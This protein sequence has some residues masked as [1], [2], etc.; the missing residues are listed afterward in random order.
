MLVGITSFG[1]VWRRRFRTSSD[2]SQRFRRAAYFNTTGVA[3][4]GEIVRHRKI[5]G[6]VRFNGVGGFN[7]YYPQRVLGSVFQCDEPAIWNRQNKVFC[8]RKLDHPER[9]DYFLVAV[10]SAEFGSVRVGT[11]S[12]KSDDTYLISFSEWRDTQEL[13]MLMSPNGWVRTQLGRVVMLHDGLR[14]WVRKPTL[15]ANEHEI[16]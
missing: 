11:E 8:V 13:L 7:P 4:N 3:V 5:A 12:W 2:D 9:P 10:R 15:R 14:P 16:P 6:H 1:S